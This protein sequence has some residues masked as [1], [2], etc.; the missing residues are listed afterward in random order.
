MINANQLERNGLFANLHQRWWSE[1]NSRLVPLP[2]RRWPRPWVWV[3]KRNNGLPIH[4]R[5]PPS[6]SLIGPS[7]QPGAIQAWTDTARRTTLTS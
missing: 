4:A 1:F 5:E 7:P 2:R 3:T 6:L